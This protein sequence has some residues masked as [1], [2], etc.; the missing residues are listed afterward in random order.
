MVIQALG[1]IIS[2]GITTRTANWLDN[3]KVTDL[4]QRAWAYGSEQ[5]GVQE[6]QEWAKDASGT[7]FRFSDAD[8]RR[9]ADQLSALD[10]D[11]DRLIAQRQGELRSVGRLSNHS[12]QL[13]LTPETR[14]NIRDK[15]D[16]ERIHELAA[17]VQMPTST[18]F[19]HQE[20]PEE[21]RTRYKLLMKTVHKL[22][23]KQ[24]RQGSILIL[25]TATL[26]ASTHKT[27][28][29][30]QSLGWTTKKGEPSGRVTGDMTYTDWPTSLN[31]KT[32]ETKEEVR[33]LV[34]AKWGTI[35]LPTLQD[36]VND[37]LLMAD[38]EG[39]DE[40]SL[41]KKDIAAAFH[42]LLFD[43]LSVTL[44]AFALDEI[45]SILHLVGNFGWTAGMPNAWDVGGRI[46]LAAANLQLHGTLKLYVDD[47]FG[48]C[49]TRHLRRN[50]TIVDDV[51]KTLLGPEA[52]APHKDKEGRT[53]VILGWLFDLELRTVAISEENLLKAL[54]S[55]MVLDVEGRHTKLQL[56]TAASLATRYSTLCRPMAQFSVELYRDIGLF[57]GN[58][59]SKRALTDGTK[60]EVALWKAYLSLTVL[61]P[62]IFAR[63]LE[64]FR[65]RPP[66]SINIGFD[67]YIQG[68]GVG[69]R[70]V[71]GLQLEEADMGQLLGYAG[72]CPIP[73]RLTN[74]SS[75]QNT[76]E[77]LAV[78]LGLLI[79]AY[80][81]RVN[82]SFSA[83]GDS[84]T[85]LSWLV[86]DRV[87]SALGKRAGIA[88]TIIASTLGAF[89]T[90]TVFKRGADN[91]L[92]DDLSRGKESEETRALPTEAKFECRPGS[93][94][95]DILAL[96]DPQHPEL[97]LKGTL[98]FITSITQLLSEV[99]EAGHA[100][101]NRKLS[102]PSTTR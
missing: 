35:T 39:W 13:T 101:R 31:G 43:P 73:W 50:N 47:F 11:L 25:P 59:H 85:T 45:Y 82:F 78:I 94:A 14:G 63:K 61:N 81:G 90:G 95:Y 16:I 99:Q 72:V 54:Y 77:L 36:I 84:M 62:L 24:Q 12:I 38:K 97:T 100:Q 10:G 65:P 79:A 96:C 92:Y 18:D 69:L 80:L 22:L 5:R 40:I 27:P 49:R 1:D 26:L 66:A 37:I 86:K 8:L 42:R 46:M 23:D 83:T 44:T 41:F 4:M 60:I 58:Q 29:H 52:L 68:V 6:A 51:I 32:N 15:Q 74:D 87:A 28:L 3:E 17:G 19:V 56:E 53:L 34:E 30:F 55:F 75:Y 88:Y 48:V 33:K 64:S 102:G 21:L 57:R 93:P 67:G 76:S 71:E 98:T 9:D 91:T 7:P 70:D 2:P 89:N 20:E